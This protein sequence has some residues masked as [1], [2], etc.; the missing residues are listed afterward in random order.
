MRATLMA[1]SLLFTSAA[2]A[3]SASEFKVVDVY[4][5]EV[6]PSRYKGKAVELRNMRCYHADD[7]DYRCI[8][9]GGATV[10]V[11]S[12]AVTPEA[13]DTDLQD[14][15]AEIRKVATSPRCRK[16]IR[17]TVRDYDSDTI[18]GNK[19]RTVIKADSIELLDAAPA[20]KRRR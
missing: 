15:C 17:F 6:N 10:M 4:D 12:T 1:V 7:E 8:S 14:Q 18:S 13:A 3:Q 20:G 5:I 11:G 16:T 9:S 2:L 19:S